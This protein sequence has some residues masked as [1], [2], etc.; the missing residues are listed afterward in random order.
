MKATRKSLQKFGAIIK[1]ELK[2]QIKTS[3]LRST[4]N[5]SSSI[6]FST[7]QLK[8]REVLTIKLPF[9]AEYL[10]RGTKGSKTK[11]F[12]NIEAISEWA[13]TKSDFSSLNKTKFEKAV[14]A[15]SAS[16][17]SKGIIKR[18]RGGSRFIDIVIDKVS[19]ELIE[20]I[21]QSYLEEISIKIDKGQNE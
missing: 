12:V 14:G 10:D 4:G 21:A 7:R 18:F 6:N 16:I 13:K 20:E 9:Y 3:D 17:A 5:L 19:P 1:K 2:N 15:I 11:R 8:A